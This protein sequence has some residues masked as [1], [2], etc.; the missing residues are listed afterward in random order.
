MFLLV[1]GMM[2]NP[3]AWVNGC[4]VLSPVYG[5]FLHLSFCYSGYAPRL[6][7]YLPCSLV[8]S[9]QHPQDV[10]TAVEPPVRLPQWT[11]ELAN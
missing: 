11:S 1:L 4:L 8:M 5:C 10:L 6:L 9:Q 7:G 3:C 2:D